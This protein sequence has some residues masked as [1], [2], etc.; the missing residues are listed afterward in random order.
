MTCFSSCCILLVLLPLI[1]WSEI[2]MCGRDIFSQGDI[3]GG[4]NFFPD[5]YGQRRHLVL[6]VGL[7]VY[8]PFFLPQIVAKVA[9]HL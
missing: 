7:S 9:Q 1:L 6:P 8:S 2:S 4:Y 5:G 3:K